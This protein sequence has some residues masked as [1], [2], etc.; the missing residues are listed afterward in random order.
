MS[1]AASTIPAAPGVRGVLPDGRV[2]SYSAN[3]GGC[4]GA[5]TNGSAAAAFAAA[6]NTA[7]GPADIV[8]CCRCC[9]CCPMASNATSRTCIT[10]VGRLVLL[11][12]LLLLLL[13]R[14]LLLILLL[15]K[16]LMLLLDRLLMLILERLLLLGKLLL[17]GPYGAGSMILAH[18]GLAPFPSLKTKPSF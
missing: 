17:L 2:V 15:G 14:L 10:R 5:T 16:L 18:M 12:R 13:G 4:D 9:R 6:D 3:A 7:T 11:G 8:H 1:Q